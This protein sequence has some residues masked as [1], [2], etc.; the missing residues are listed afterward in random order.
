MTVA[1]GVQ[2]WDP[3]RLGSGP[4]LGLLSLL[5]FL[6]M[7]SLLTT[8]PH[9]LTL[10]NSSFKF[11]ITF[12]FSGESLSRGE[13]PHF[14]NI[15]KHFKFWCG[16]GLSGFGSFALGSA[17]LLSFSPFF[18]VFTFLC[19]LCTRIESSLSRVV[20]FVLCTFCV[21][22]AWGIKI[23]YSFM[24]QNGGTKWLFQHL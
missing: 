22:C 7:G 24:L 23:P 10:F 5:R 13:P 16:S 6:M 19:V 12:L 1:G 18:H 9:F 8:P 2:G 14:L 21:L 4:C 17:W 3:G 11:L 20:L 15:F